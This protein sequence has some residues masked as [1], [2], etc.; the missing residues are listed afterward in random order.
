M[1]LPS[2]AILSWILTGFVLLCFDNI[3]NLLFLLLLETDFV[4]VN[5][6]HLLLILHH[7]T[8]EI[9]WLEEWNI[10]LLK[11]MAGLRNTSEGGLVAR[12]IS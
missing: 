12:T 1:C 6:C 4:I 11:Q 7:F 8:E 5:L 3:T 2:S 10:M 9:L